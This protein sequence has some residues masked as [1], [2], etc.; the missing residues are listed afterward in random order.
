MLHESRTFSL[1]NDEAW[2]RNRGFWWFATLHLD[3]GPVT[4]MFQSLCN[5]VS[6]CGLDL[7]HEIHSK[8]LKE[9]LRE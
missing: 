5:D 3:P 8:L 7:A 1:A 4:Q 9:M 6:D 2:Q